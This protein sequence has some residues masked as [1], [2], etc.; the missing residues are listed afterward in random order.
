MENRKW[1]TFL[2]PQDFLSLSESLKGK[3]VVLNTAYSTLKGKVRD[4]VEK[5]DGNICI[6]V[7]SLESRARFTGKHW[8][9]YHQSSIS[10][11]L[12]DVDTTWL[13]NNET[14]VYVAFQNTNNVTIQRSGM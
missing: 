3:G 13:I 5:D 10:I 2:S 9:P 6:T 1:D 14:A 7:D 12:T 8:Q 4:V 11:I